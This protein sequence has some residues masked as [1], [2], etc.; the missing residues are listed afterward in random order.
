MPA[1]K[2]PSIKT[3]PSTHPFSIFFSAHIIFRPANGRANMVSITI[4]CPRVFCG[5]LFIPFEKPPKSAN[6]DLTPL[7]VD[8]DKSG[9][10]FHHDQDNHQPFQ[11]D[12]TP[13]VCLLGKDLVNFP[14]RI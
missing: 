7:V 8:G 4:N 10:D 6:S 5:S 3:S 14:N 13:G 12:E 2:P 11:N 9:D 1:K